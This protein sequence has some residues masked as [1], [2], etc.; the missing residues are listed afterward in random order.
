MTRRLSASL[1][2]LTLLGLASL[3]GCGEDRGPAYDS[4]DALAMAINKAA[5]P[6]LD[7]PAIVVEPDGYIGAA[8]NGSCSIGDDSAQVHLY[9]SASAAEDDVDYLGS[10]NPGSQIFLGENWVLVARDAD[11]LDGAMPGQLFTHP[12]G[13]YAVDSA[14]EGGLS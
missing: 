9:T 12:G 1:A 8:A 10:V 2:G 6:A 3:T 5:R 7:C 14:D 4:V 11:K 13:E